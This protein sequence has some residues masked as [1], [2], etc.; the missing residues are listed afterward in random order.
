M[1]PPL[2][3]ARVS[4]LDR[5]RRGLVRVSGPQMKWSLERAAEIAGLGMGVLDVA[6]IPP[7]RLAELSRYGVDGRRRCGGDTVMRAV[8]RRCWPPMRNRGSLND[9]V[10]PPG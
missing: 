6:G 1:P 8:R 4:E 9:E 2:A 7:R 5:L 10:E 3:R